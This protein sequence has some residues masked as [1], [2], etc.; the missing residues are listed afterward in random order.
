MFG[1]SAA[2]LDEEIEHQ[3]RLFDSDD[4]AEA[5]AAFAEKRAPHFQEQPRAHFQ[6]D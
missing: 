2:T 4:F 3:V 5:V 6:A 1:P